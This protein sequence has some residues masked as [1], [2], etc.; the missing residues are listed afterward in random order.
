MC[1]FLIRPSFGA[2]GYSFGRCPTVPRICLLQSCPPLAKGCRHMT[3]F[4]RP[5]NAYRRPDGGFRTVRRG[6]LLRFTQQPHV[7][8]LWHPNGMKV[9]YPAPGTVSASDLG[10]SHV[11]RARRPFVRD[12]EQHQL[13]NLTYAVEL[14][15]TMGLNKEKMCRWF[16]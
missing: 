14:V 16:P 8:E 5:Q 11:C 7:A 13:R 15:A 2:Q 4:P 1:N 12:S 9:G 3:G 6:I 10:S